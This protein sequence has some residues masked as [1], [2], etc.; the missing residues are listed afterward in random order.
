MPIDIWNGMKHCVVVSNIFYFH[1][2]LGKWSHLTNIFQMGWNHQLEHIK[3]Y[4]TFGFWKMVHFLGV[5]QSQ[6]EN[7]FEVVLE[8]WFTTPPKF[9]IDPENGAWKTMVSYHGHVRTFGTWCLFFSCQL[10]VQ[11]TKATKVTWFRIHGTGIFTYI[12]LIYLINV[13]KYTILGYYGIELFEVGIEKLFPIGIQWPDKLFFIGIQ[14]PPFTKLSDQL[15]IPTT[16][17]PSTPRLS[18]YLEGYNLANLW[19]SR[20]LYPLAL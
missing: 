9:N 10:G 13:G 20:P 11:W 3:M 7:C 15:K 5:A 19:L 17:S 6:R 8:G 2:Y 1:P 12:C 18:G 4:H 14:W 16:K